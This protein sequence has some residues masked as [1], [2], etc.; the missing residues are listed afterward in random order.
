MMH[1]LVV[2]L[3]SI[4]LVFLSDGISNY[5]VYARTEE[6]T[7]PHFLQMFLVYSS[8]NCRWCKIII[9]CIVPILPA[10]EPLSSFVKHSEFSLLTWN[11]LLL[12]SQDNWWC[13]KQY[14]SNVGIEKRQWKHRQSLINE[15]LLQSAADIVCIPE[16]DGDWRHVWYWLCLHGL[17]W[18]W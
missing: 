6:K 5:P 11:T 15:R 4:A 9:Y 10:R 18:T 16:A 12:N 17:G 8:S 7:V 1:S 3:S 2:S 14:S 13:H